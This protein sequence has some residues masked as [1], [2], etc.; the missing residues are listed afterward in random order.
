MNDK[1]IKNFWKKVKVSDESS[2]WVWTGGKCNHGY[3]QIK[4]D[5][6]DRMAHRVSWN[7]HFGE[8][9]DKLLVCHKCDNPECVNPHH[10]F[11][12]THQ[13]N[14][15]DR[16]RKGRNKHLWGEKNGSSKL[17]DSQIHSIRQKYQT[18]KYSLRVLAKE[19]GVGFE[20]IR[21]VV[22]RI[23]FKNI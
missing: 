22:K 7:I 13:D 3:G 17:K 8:I 4:I 15:D 2:C 10:L 5:G 1:N 9:P 21:R 14:M 19:Y 20:A 6:K 18:G 11:L 12:G 16:N 23:S